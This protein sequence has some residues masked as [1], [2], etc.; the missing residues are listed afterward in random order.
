MLYLSAGVGK[1]MPEE[2][3][4]VYWDLLG[5]FPAEALRWAVKKALLENTYPVIPQVGV[6]DRYCRIYLFRLGQHLEDRAQRERREAAK[7]TWERLKQFRL[8]H[9]GE[10]SRG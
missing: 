1:P 10:V 8:G 7:L 4:R 9:F 3:A 6:L 5:K 2:T